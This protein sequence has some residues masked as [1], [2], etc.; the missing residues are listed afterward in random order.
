ML[1]NQPARTITKQMQ[2]KSTRKSPKRA[3]RGKFSDKTIKRI[4]ERDGGRCVRCGSPYIESVP[5][6]IIYRSQGGRGDE[7]NG[8]CICRPC[9]DLAHS[10]EVVRRWFEQYR[11]EKLLT[12]T[13]DAI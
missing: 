1:S 2:T 4:I 12:Q 10:K 6:H 11:I 9:H 5:H 7:D 8:V 13:E 3:N